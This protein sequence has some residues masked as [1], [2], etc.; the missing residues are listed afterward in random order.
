MDKANKFLFKVSA[1]FL[2]FSTKIILSAPL[3]MH[4][5]PKDPIPE[6]RS[7][8]FDSSKS[9]LIKF[10]CVIILKI[11][12]FTESLSGLVIFDVMKSIDFPLNF[13]LDVEWFS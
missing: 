2:S 5:N 1:A 6:Y 10:E 7:N 12:S 9:I 3:D 11:F 13:L 4:S 8:I